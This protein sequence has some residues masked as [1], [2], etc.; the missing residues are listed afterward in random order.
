LRKLLKNIKAHSRSDKI[1]E[2]AELVGVA[3]DTMLREN[4]HL[5]KAEFRVDI[6]K[7]LEFDFLY[8]RFNRHCSALMQKYFPGLSL[9]HF[10]G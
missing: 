9:N 2:L 4:A 1:D 7:L 3:A 10:L 6:L 5:N 8:D